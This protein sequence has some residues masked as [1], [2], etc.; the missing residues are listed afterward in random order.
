MSRHGTLHPGASVCAVVPHLACEAWLGTALASLERQTR[1]PDAVVVIDDASPDPAALLAVA[2]AHPGTTV[3]RADRNV[4]PYALV[5]AVVD[6]G[7][8]DAYLFQDADDWSAPD[9]LAVLLATAHRT[10]ADLV[11][12][13]ELRIL[14]DAGEAMPVAYPTDV[15]AACAADPTAFALL[16]PTS[17]ASAALLGRLGGFSTGLRFSGDAELLWRAVHAGRVV[18]APVLAYGRRRRAGSLTTDPAT[19][20]G[21]PSRLA[22]HGRLHAAARARAD[23]ARRGGP[24][25]LAPYLVAAEPPELAHVAGPALTTPAPVGAAR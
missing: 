18:N 14:A 8:F 6:L 21:S 7:L 1:R 2:A 12:S 22:L 13:W 10:G 20:L 4:G 11:G 9:R 19:G 25:D 5:Q 23:A 24:V 17:L 3:L 15:N 16:H